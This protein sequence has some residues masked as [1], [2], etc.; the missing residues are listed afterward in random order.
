MLKL[1]GL[2]SLLMATPSQYWDTFYI[3]V[4]LVVIIVG[5]ILIFAIVK[6]IQLWRKPPKVAPLVQGEK[7][8]PDKDAKPGE[9]VFVLYRGEYW[10]AKSPTGIEKGVAYRVSGKDGTVLTLEPLK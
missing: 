7:I 3:I 1:S 2:V 5:A 10:K 4:A 8:V 9:E 6:S